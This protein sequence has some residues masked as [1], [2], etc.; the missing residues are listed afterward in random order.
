MV[1]FCILISVFFIPGP[2]LFLKKKLIRK[3]WFFSVIL[4]FEYYIYILLL[5]QNKKN[6]NFNLIKGTKIGT[7]MFLFEVCDIFLL[8]ILSIETSSL[9]VVCMW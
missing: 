6:E 7:L 3:F 9:H 5:L 2:F 8:H 4:T 1:N